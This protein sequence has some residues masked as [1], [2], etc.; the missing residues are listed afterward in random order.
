MLLWQ[1]AEI[2]SLVLVLMNYNTLITAH[3]YESHLY[4][5]LY[6]LVDFKTFLACTHK[7]QVNQTAINCKSHYMYL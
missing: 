3:I 1:I 4:V 5:S 6:T 2:I 7:S